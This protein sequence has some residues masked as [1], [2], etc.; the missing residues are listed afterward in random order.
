MKKV[1]ID[2]KLKQKVPG[3]CLAV[4]S[5]E[6]SILPTDDTIKAEVLTIEKQERSALTLETL[7]KQPR[8]LEARQGYKALGKDPSRYRLATESLLRRI[9]KGNGL[10]Y[11]CNAVDIGNILSVKT[12]RSVA[13]LDEEE[14]QGDIIIRIGRNEPFEGMGRGKLNVEHIP[15]YCDELGP[16]GSPT[17]D[18]PRTKIKATTKQIL[19]FITSF[20]GTIG[21]EEDVE[22]AKS[23]FSRFGG[24]V[25]FSL[26]M[27]E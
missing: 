12:R 6:M 26:E 14:I 8:I 3:Y 13:V 10:Y 19:L 11:V 27:V 15:V 23:L 16:F 7:L 1:R 18:T 4:M 5:F 20:N 22:L 24:V 17:S 25:N 9:I 2:E 21:L